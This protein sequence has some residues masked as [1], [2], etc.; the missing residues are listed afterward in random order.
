[1]IYQVAY[2]FKL[3]FTGERFSVEAE[4]VADAVDCALS[5]IIDDDDAWC[6]NDNDSW[7]IFDDCGSV[8]AT[9]NL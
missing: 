5:Y 2:Q 3:D 8:V 4:N 9:I 6:I 1:M 7:V